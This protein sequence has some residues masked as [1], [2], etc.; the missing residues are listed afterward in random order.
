M[1]ASMMYKGGERMVS[2]FC[3]QPQNERPQLQD[4]GRST[5]IAGFC[6]NKASGTCGN[7]VV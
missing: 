6:V 2:D 7:V 1:K 4:T 5:M 3:P